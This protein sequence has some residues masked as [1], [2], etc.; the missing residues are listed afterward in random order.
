MERR[1]TPTTFEVRSGEDGR[2]T[3]VGY[4]AVFD[5]LSVPLP[6]WNGPFQER[7]ARGAF[8]NVLEGDTRALWNHDANFV[9][10]R[11]RSGTLRLEEDAY[12]LRV[13]IS[14]P[15]NVL[16]QAFLESIARGDVT[17][18]SFAFSVEKD[19]QTWDRAAEP[20]VRTIHTVSA[21][22][23]VSPVT[24]PA[25]PQTEVLLRAFLGDA[26]QEDGETLSELLAEPVVEAV[27]ETLVD[28][29]DELVENQDKESDGQEPAESVRDAGLRA[30]ADQRE[31]TIR[32]LSV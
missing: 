14:P 21:L 5:Q 9:L 29:V 32:L 17:Q 1:L 26:P 2:R 16:T 31:R 8:R 12:G 11:T 7:L 13:E 20:H 30:Q 4:A 3:L 18:M 27:D 25:Y 10:G 22:A 24:Y 23:D 19:G 15:E 28:A 6:G